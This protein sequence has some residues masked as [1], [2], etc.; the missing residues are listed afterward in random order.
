MHHPLRAL[1]RQYALQHSV[2]ELHATAVNHQR[3]VIERQSTVDIRRNRGI[4]PLL[5]VTQHCEQ[6]IDCR[7]ER[8]IEDVGVH[9]HYRTV[10]CRAICALYNPLDGLI[11]VACGYPCRSA[12]RHV[13]GVNL[14]PCEDI[15]RAFTKGFVQIGGILHCPDVSGL[16]RH[17]KTIPTD[18]Q[19]ILSN[20]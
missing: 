10:T 1:L 5:L 19:R 7:C 3:T 18:C 11:G 8:L 20:L 4:A 14:L 15:Q 9:R 13:Q 16:S 17:C 6:A 2:I 12:N